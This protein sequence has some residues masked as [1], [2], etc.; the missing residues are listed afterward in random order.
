MAAEQTAAL[1]AAKNETSK[2]VLSKQAEVERGR[3][4]APESPALSGWGAPGVRREDRDCRSPGLK[5]GFRSRITQVKAL[6][7]LEG[8]DKASHA[9]ATTTCA[10]SADA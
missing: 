3:I 9:R 2:P 7:Y 5:E 6:G 8:E 1:V 4:E 10:S